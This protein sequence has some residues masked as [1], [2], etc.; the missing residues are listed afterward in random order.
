MKYN[1]KKLE[2]K[3]NLKYIIT[4]MTRLYNTQDIKELQPA[5]KVI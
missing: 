3:K 5:V 2:I 4:L 1:N